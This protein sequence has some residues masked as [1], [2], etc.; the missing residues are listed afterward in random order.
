METYQNKKYQNQKGQ[1]LFEIIVAITVVSIGMLAVVGLI[2]TSVSDA[3]LSKNQNLANRK[4]Q[5][6]LEWLRGERDTNWALFV[7]HGSDIGTVYCLDNLN[8]DNAG[9][10]S[11]SE[12]ISGTPLIRELIFVYDLADA[13]KASLEV[14]T[15]WS[16]QTGEH[17]SRSTLVLTNWRGN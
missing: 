4:T 8:F 13:N 11:A 14:V 10:C 6:A 17:D 1:S 2:R 5:E 3:D 7:A 12:F 15:K 16:D 9:E